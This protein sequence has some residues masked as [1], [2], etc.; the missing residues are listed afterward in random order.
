MNIL[1]AN[2]DLDV[3]GPKERV[4]YNMEDEVMAYSIK[5]RPV[6]FFSITSLLVMFL[7]P[8]ICFA[9]AHNNLGLACGKSGI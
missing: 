3:V 4:S 6:L 1:A 8:A 2:V 9:G 7:V 5:K